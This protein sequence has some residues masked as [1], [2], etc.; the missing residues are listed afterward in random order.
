MLRQLLRLPGLLLVLAVVSGAGARAVGQPAPGLFD[1]VVAGGRVVD[2]TGAAWFRA[3]VGVRGDRIAAIG[4]LHA[5]AASLRIDATG[6]VVA[7]GFIDPHVHARERLRDLPTAEGYLLQGLTT[8]VDGNDGSS[9]L[10][11]A[12]WFEELQTA[13]MSPNVALFVGHGT[14]REAVMGAAN[15]KATPAELAKM[16]ALVAE[17]MR[18]GALGLSSGLAYVPGAYAPTDELVAL[19]RTAGEHGGIY[20]S[21]MRDEGGGVLDSVRETIAIG[22][23]AKLPVQ[24]SHHKVGGRRQ[25]GQSV[26]SLELIAAARRRGVDVTFDQYPYTAS[27]TGLAIVFPRWALADGKLH[28]RLASPG[29]R[30]EIKT[31]MLSFIDERFGDDP[32]RIQLVRCGHDPSLAGKT[33]ADLLTA[34]RQPLTQSATAEAVI[35]LQLKGGCSAILHSYDEP[36]VERFMQSPY[37]MIGSDGSLTTPGDGSP[38]PRAFGTYPRVLGRYVRERGVLTLEDAIRKMTSFPAARLG[39]TGR[40]VLKAGLVADITVFDAETIADVATFSDPHHY[41]VGV[42]Y[43]LVNGQVTVAMGA[44]TGVRAGRVVR[45]PAAAGR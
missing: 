4:D 17:A 2:G 19:A 18:E 23:G 27:Q 24:I 32:S 20:I 35:E 31:G 11:I 12:P 44:H 34:A 5:A 7:P 8:V 29:Q 43:V 41:S 28:E 3:D 25:F 26:Q 39:L 40:G 42:R 9:P 22:E 10:P 16:Q 14:V 6:L 33:I 21:H 30:R 15:R 45:G 38:H 36:D 1:V 37:G 13:T